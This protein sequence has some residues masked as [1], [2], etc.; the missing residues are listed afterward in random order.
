MKRAPRQ[1]EEP[2]PGVQLLSHMELKVTSLLAKGLTRKD[3]SQRLGVSLHTTNTHIERIYEKLAAHNA[4][5]AVAKVI[6]ERLLPVTH[7]SYA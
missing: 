3:I 5:E 2:L 7:T 1:A 4:A 6:E